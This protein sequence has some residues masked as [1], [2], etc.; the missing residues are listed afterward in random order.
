MHLVLSGFIFIYALIGCSDGGTFSESGG[1][2][3]SPAKKLDAERDQTESEMQSDQGRPTS[4]VSSPDS[5]A[6][7]NPDA[8]SL[9]QDDFTDPSEDERVHLPQQV[10]GVLLTCSNLISGDS[11]SAVTCHYV[12]PNQNPKMDARLRNADNWDMTGVKEGFEVIGLK[13]PSTDQIAF[14][15]DITPSDDLFLAG[16]QISL[17]ISPHKDGEILNAKT[18]YE[19]DQPVTTMNPELEA[20]LK[21]Q[22]NANSEVNS[23]GYLY[24]KG[25]PISEQTPKIIKMNNSTDQTTEDYCTQKTGVR[26]NKACWFLGKKKQSCS[27]VCN[28]MNLK[29]DRATNK[30]AGKAGSRQ[31]CDKILTLLGVDAGKAGGFGVEG[32]NYPDNLGCHYYTGSG[33]GRVYCPHQPANANGSGAQQKRVCACKE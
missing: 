1:L 19:E 12:D 18:S 29:F 2:S 3:L 31:N 33:S 16:A 14:V 30:I 11:L 15:F 25:I 5:A 26:A 17:F 23:I 27:Q 28:G 32:F 8:D 13:K 10:T 20:Y 7:S 6:A 4:S 21:A 22:L 24:K 9:P